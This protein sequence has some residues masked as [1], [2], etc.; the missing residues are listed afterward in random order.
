MS[1]YI[2][3][4]NWEK[5]K[6]RWENS[7]EI[8]KIWLQFTRWEGARSLPYPICVTLDAVELLR[9]YTFV[10]FGLETLVA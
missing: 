5:L 7:E 4:H 9:S 1:F 3:H 10:G 8:I 6:E 2:I